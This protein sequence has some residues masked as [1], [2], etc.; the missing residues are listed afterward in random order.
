MRMS[1]LLDVLVSLGPSGLEKCANEVRSWPDLGEAGELP[2]SGEAA[3]QEEI[4]SPL[5]PLKRHTHTRD[6]QG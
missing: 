1:Y 5:S 4:G 2:T 3:S 6:M